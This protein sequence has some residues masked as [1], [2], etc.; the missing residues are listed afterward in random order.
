MIGGIGRV[1]NVI[2][3]EYANS[4]KESKQHNPPRQMT[5]RRALRICASFRPANDE[6]RRLSQIG[7]FFFS[8]PQNSWNYWISVRRQASRRFAALSMNQ[9]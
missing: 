6:N 1:D 5:L 9:K 4:Q 2:L 7:S 8:H 3:N